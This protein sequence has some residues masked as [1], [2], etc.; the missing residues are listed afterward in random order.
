MFP[1]NF[2]KI[3]TMTYD[4]SNFKKRTKE[5]DEHLKKEFAGI[6]TGRAA[7]AILDGVSVES[8]GA[9]LSLKE[10]GSITVEDARTLKISPWDASQAKNIEK[11]IA[12]ANLDLS[13]SIGDTG[14]RVFF[15]ELTAE[16]R[17]AILKV[18]KEKLEQTKVTLRQERDHIWKDIQEKEK[19][20]G[21]GED[22]K[23]R[24]KNELQKEVDSANK[25]F[26]EHFGKKEKEIK[27]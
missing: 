20:G 25:N 24:L 16:R 26:D 5:I 22:E 3:I 2:G 23:F 6:R 27:S 18:A 4:F 7:P 12:T 10:L 14:I 19:T 11:A 9:K 1:V 17:E 8:Y 13:V 21:M 15:P